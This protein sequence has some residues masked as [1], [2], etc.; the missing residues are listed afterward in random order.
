MLVQSS[1]P[2]E[3]N[4]TLLYSNTVFPSF[5]E[6]MSM[7]RINDV[8]WYCKSKDHYFSRII[9]VHYILLLIHVMRTHCRV[10]HGKIYVHVQ[11]F[12]AKR[13]NSFPKKWTIY[14]IA[15]IVLFLPSS[16]IVKMYRM[17][18]RKSILQAIILL[19]QKIYCGILCSWK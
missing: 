12:I 9:F 5:F 17:K 6:S 13:V 11:S 18:N 4:C 2:F 15:T 7:S 8:I 19:L 16:C 10:R 3:T 1:R 14:Q